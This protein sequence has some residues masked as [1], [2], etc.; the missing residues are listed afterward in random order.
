MKYFQRQMIRS[1]DS[2]FGWRPNPR[3]TEKV[4]NRCVH[5]LVSCAAPHLKDTGKGKTT[6]LYDYVKQVIGHWITNNQTIGD[7]VSHGH[8][9]AIR[10]LACTEIAWKGE[11]EKWLADIATEPIYAG[12]RV[13]IGGGQLGDGDGSLGAWASEWVTRNGTHNRIAYGGIDLSN[14]SGSRAKEWGRARNGCPDELEPVGKDH[15][16]KTASLVQSWEGVRDL[17]A[18]GYPVTVASN[19]GFNSTRDSQGFCSPSGTW[20]HEM[21]FSGADDDSSRPGAL[22]QNSWGENWVS[23]PTRLGQP[24]GSFWVDA[25]VVDRMVRQDDSWGLS[26]YVGFPKRDFSHMMF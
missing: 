12:S 21:M 22:C 3:E 24:P 5:P 17:L 2:D 10:T 1:G 18:S 6:L 20:M 26:S 16:V 11:S 14:Y 8:A 4:L 9:Q 7:C 23:G 25:E 19:Q 13:E 15:L